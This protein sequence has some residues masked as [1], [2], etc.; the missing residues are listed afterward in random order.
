MID[1]FYAGVLPHVDP[2]SQFVP[3]DVIIERCRPKEPL[4]EDINPSGWYSKW[5]ARWVLFVFPA[6]D[7]RDQ[8]LDLALAHQQKR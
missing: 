5:L 7:V 2:P 8:A 6:S 3:S 4:T 1:A